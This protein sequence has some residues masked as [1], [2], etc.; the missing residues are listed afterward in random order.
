MPVIKFKIRF[1]VVLLGLLFCPLT[2]TAYELGP[3]Q[4]SDYSQT[5]NWLALPAAIEKPVDVFYLYPTAWA[6]PDGH[7]PVSCA[8]DDPAM[9]SRARM[10]YDAQATALETVGNMYAPFYRQTDAVVALTMTPAE[11]D[12]LMRDIPVA[13]AKAAFDYF[14]K[15]HNQGRPFILA[16]HSQGST[17]MLLG[18]LFDYLKE[19]PEVNQRLVAAYVLGYTVTQAELDANPHLKF[20]TGR[21]DTGVIIA[22]IT[23]SPGFNDANPVL[24]PG[25]LVINPISWTLTAEPATSGQSL[26]ARINGKDYPRYAYLDL[27]RG[28]V[29]CSTAD[30]ALFT[31]AG[32]G[33]LFAAGN[34]HSGD[35]PL[36]Y[37]DL[38]QNARD[39]AEAFLR[40]N[41]R[42]NLPIIKEH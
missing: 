14:I 11:R 10:V 2:A 36:Y 28:V 41:F 15:N 40:E 8:V 3:T 22:Y 20:A 33:G 29:K 1:C 30:T 12:A 32:G 34:L 27:E 37:F 31:T 39:R 18:I 42:N 4:T 16:S 7:G 35:W 5:D 17:V 25:A 26:G 19:N 6:Q 24:L 21:N 23:E 9:R 38:R 13:D